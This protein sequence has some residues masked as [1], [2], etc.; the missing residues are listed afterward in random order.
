MMRK[1][2]TRARSLKR[3]FKATKA[4]KMKK[5]NAKIIDRGRICTVGKK[6]T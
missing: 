3:P 6:V 4:K 5:K 1:K 2:N